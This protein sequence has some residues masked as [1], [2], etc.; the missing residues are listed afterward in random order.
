MFNKIINNISLTK[1]SLYLEKLNTGNYN[2][3]VKA[4][5][6][7][8]K[9]KITKEIGLRIIDNATYKYSKE[10]TDMNINSMILL[11][12]FNDYKKEYGDAFVDNF[13]EY[14][15]QTKLDLL[16]Y[17]SSS[18]DIN[19]ILLW[20]YLVLYRFEPTDNKLP[21][22]NLSNNKDNYDILFPDL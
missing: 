6:K 5:E 4:Y 15:Y 9:I 19:A 3:K 21:I 13:D 10:F 7:L 8:K 11:L 2:Q 16:S 22:G 1:A 18:E 20:K 14:D 12:C 17:L